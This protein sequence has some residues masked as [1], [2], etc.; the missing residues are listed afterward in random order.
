MP[1]L[2]L[3]SAGAGIELPL[4]IAATT[5]DP[6]GLVTST[7]D[8]TVVD[9]IAA[10]EIA[11]GDPEVN[12]GA[13]TDDPAPIALGMTLPDAFVER[14]GDGI[15]DVEAIDTGLILPAAVVD[16]TGAR[17]AD[18]LAIADGAMLPTAIVNIT[19]PGTDD[20]GPIV[21]VTIAPETG[22]A[23]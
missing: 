21:A 3:V 16:R 5:I 19:G 6:A 18:P 11:P 15:T 12:P 13:G 7:G 10:G 8:G 17:N 20:P 22:P 1:V 2:T 14:T 9:N 4:A 23:V